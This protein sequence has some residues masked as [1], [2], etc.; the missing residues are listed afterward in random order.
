MG[1]AAVT[2]AG[3]ANLAIAID[4]RRN[5]HQLCHVARPGTSANNDAWIVRKVRLVDRFGDSSYLVRC[6][7]E[8][9][10]GVVEPAIGLDTLLYAAAADP[11]RSFCAIAG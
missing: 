5:G 10:G 4:I 1:T 8:L 2:A 6:Q 7:M 3:E 9:D 11:S